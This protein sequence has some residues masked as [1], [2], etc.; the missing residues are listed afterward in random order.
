MACFSFHPRKVLTTGEGGMITTADEK[1]SE[2]L[3]R[4][5]QHGMTVS[6]LARHSSSKVLTECYVDIGYNYRMTDMQAAI[7]IVQLNRLDKMLERRRALAANYA[8]GLA[9]LRWLSLPDDT[10]QCRHNFQSYMVRLRSDAPVT[11]DIFMQR[12]LDSGISTRRG[13]MAI[14]RE[15]PYYKPEWDA[16]LP[17]TNAITDSTVILPLYQDMTAS[18]QEYVIGNIQDIGMRS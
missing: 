12:L 13:V 7:G 5:R 18:D 15:P 2:Q 6:D 8:A 11:R 3:R 17:K 4:L 16:R 10:A 14:H 1:L 9:S